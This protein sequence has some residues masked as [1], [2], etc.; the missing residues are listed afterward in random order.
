MPRKYVLSWSKTHKRWHKT[1]NGKKYYFRKSRSKADIEAYKGSVE[2]YERLIAGEARKQRRAA[3][4]KVAES[5]NE[6]DRQYITRSDRPTTAQ[7]RG[8]YSY[9]ST[10][11]AGFAE[12]YYEYEISRAQ[13]GQITLKRLHNISREV[14]YFVDIFLKKQAQQPNSGIILNEKRVTNYYRHLMSRLAPTIKYPKPIV[15]LMNCHATLM[16]INFHFLNYF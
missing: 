2:D 4:P 16:T 11:V 6:T 10:S 7:K 3:T 12:R 14:S 8:S 9:P 1:V 15:V 5:P 13:A